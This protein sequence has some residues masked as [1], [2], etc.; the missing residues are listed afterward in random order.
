MAFRTYIMDFYS[1]T[2]RSLIQDLYGLIFLYSKIAFKTYELYIAGWDMGLKT[3]GLY[4]AGWDMGFKTDGGF[5]RRMGHC[6]Q[7][8]WTF[9]LIWPSR[10]T[11][12]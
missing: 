4:I 1:R 11:G 12:R 9:T 3:Y 8:L 5:F 10:L 7:D 2:G 6:S